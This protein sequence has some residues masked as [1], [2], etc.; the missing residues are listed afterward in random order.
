[1]QYLSRMIGV[2]DE[3]QEGLEKVVVLAQHNEYVC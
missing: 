2:I 3:N 1:M